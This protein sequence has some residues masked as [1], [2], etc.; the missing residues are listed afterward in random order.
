[1]L[2]I[3]HWYRWTTNKNRKPHQNERETVPAKPMASSCFA[4]HLRTVTGNHQM[5]R[6]QWW[7]SLNSRQSSLSW[8]TDG[9]LTEHYL[10]TCLKSTTA[11]LHPQSYMSSSNHVQSPEWFIQDSFK[12]PYKV[13]ADSDPLGLK[14]YLLLSVTMVTVNCIGYDYSAVQVESRIRTSTSVSFERFISDVG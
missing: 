14:V 12:G 7:K 5:S 3:C 13:T 2:H 8:T 1:M 6:E 4:Q 10:W 11:E 9:R